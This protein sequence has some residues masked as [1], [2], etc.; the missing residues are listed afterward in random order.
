MKAYIGRH[1]KDGTKP[2][3]IEIRI[4]RYDAWNA[5]HTLSLIIAP[6]LKKLRENL[7]GYPGDLCVMKE[8]G[9][10]IEEHCDGMER[11]K[12]ILDKMI[13]SF[14][15]VAS[16]EDVFDGDFHIVEPVYYEKGEVLPDGTPATWLDCKVKAVMN[17]DAIDA[18]H[19]HLQEGFDLFAKYFRNL[20]D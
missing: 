18:Y 4:D 3:K 1:S 8:N 16:Q 9:W 5:D 2:R 13:W 14:E 11:W 17:Q 19:D 15:R 10:E 20:W 7:H 12:L 6:V